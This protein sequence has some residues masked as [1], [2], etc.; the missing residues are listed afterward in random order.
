VKRRLVI[1]AAVGVPLFLLAAAWQGGRFAALAAEARKIEAAQREWLE[2]NRKLDASIRV[3]SSREKAE[4][5]AERLGLEKAK[6]EERLIVEA[7]KEAK[8]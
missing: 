1:A 2:E 6:P 5:R 8:P 3:L 7:P 4:E